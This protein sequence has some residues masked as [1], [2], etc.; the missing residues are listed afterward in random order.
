M[1][2]RFYTFEAKAI[3]AYQCILVIPLDQ[4]TICEIVQGLLIKQKQ[5]RKYVEKSGGA[6]ANS[7][8]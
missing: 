6:F 7:Y 8:C 2:F 1:L 4:Y 5:W 3:E